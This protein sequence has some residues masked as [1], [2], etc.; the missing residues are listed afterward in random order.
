MALDCKLVP[1][2][3]LPTWASQVPLPAANVTPV[4]KTPA[5]NAMAATLT[6]VQMLL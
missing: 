3:F 5:R 4:A 1:S 6:N 2:L